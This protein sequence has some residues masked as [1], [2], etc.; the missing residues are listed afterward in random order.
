MA[1]R[2]DDQEQN[3]GQIVR[4]VAEFKVLV[5]PTGSLAQIA[6]QFCLSPRP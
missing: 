6:L 3:L 2:V 1:E 5:D 4:R